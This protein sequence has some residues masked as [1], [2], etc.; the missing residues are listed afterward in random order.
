M[1][2]IRKIVVT[3]GPC[4]GKST[5]TGW[6]QQA[7]SKQG[8]TV[9]FIPETATELISGGVAPWTCGTNLDYQRCQVQLQLEKER[10]F[11]QAAMTMPGEK[12]LIV[13]DRGIMDNLAYMTH[14]EFLIILD[15]LGLKEKELMLSY[16][17]IFH[18]VSAA[19]G[20]SQFYTLDNNTARTE[21]PEQA[22]ILDDKVLTAWHE[23]PQL[24]IIENC[25]GFNH[26]MEHLVNEI[27]DVLGLSAVV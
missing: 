23:H 16:D 24:H 9:L 27:A 3:G 1:K 5:A 19:K 21:T 25:S 20:L 14:D 10:I 8:Y 2:E 13:C 7:F 26:K 15:E 22:A 6:I 4:A 12:F 17:A 18:L 11:L